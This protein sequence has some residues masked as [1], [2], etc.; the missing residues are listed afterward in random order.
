MRTSRGRGRTIVL[1]T[2]D[3]HSVDR[4]CDRALLIE[5]G[6]IEEQGDPGDVARRY[7]A[8]NFEDYHG[9]DEEVLDWAPSSGR[10]VEF[11]DTW[12]ELPSGERSASF[13]EGG[14][15]RLRARLELTR[16]IESPTFNFHLVNEEGVLV[17]APKPFQI[18]GGEATV[19]AR[20]QIELSMTIDTA[21]SVGHYAI[22]CVVGLEEP[23][24]EIL[25]YRKHAV[26]FVVFGIQDFSGIAA[27]EFEAEARRQPVNAPGSQPS[28]GSGPAGDGSAS[29]GRGTARRV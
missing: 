10:S 27:L 14:P 12:A 6:R 4:K 24:R 11:L 16:P 8:I 17:F 7:L 19:D 1:V 3:V 22:Q 25:A 29:P 5:D 9:S 21:L 20:E 13:P 28:M 26:D 2:H 23:V 15:I 18:V